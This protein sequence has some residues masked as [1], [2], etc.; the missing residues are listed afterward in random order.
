[1]PQFPYEAG[2]SLRQWLLE[3]PRSGEARAR[4]FAGVATALAYVHATGLVHR[5]LKPDNVL[6][7]ID[8]SAKLADFGISMALEGGG[9]YSTLATSIGGGG[10]GTTAYKSPEQLRGERATPASDAYALGLL[11]HEL[12]YDAPYALSLEARAGGGAEAPPLPASAPPSL[13][14][15]PA[16]VEASAS[17][18]RRLLAPVAAD[19]PLLNAVL[20][21]PVCARAPALLQLRAAPG[22]PLEPGHAAV[23]EARRLMGV[24]LG[25]RPSPRPLA[26]PPGDALVPALAAHIAVS[27]ADAPI[28]T[29]PWRWDLSMGADG[30]VDTERALDAF[31]SASMRPSLQLFVGEEAVLPGAKR[32][33]SEPS[34]LA[35]GAALAQAA[36]QGAVA[37]DALGRLPPFFFDVLQR[38]AEDVLARDLCSLPSALAALA[39]VHPDKA[40]YYRG[41]LQGRAD[42]GALQ[43]PDYLGVPR[44]ITDANKEDVVR[45]DCEDVLV[46]RCGDAWALLRRGFSLG[47]GQL[48]LDAMA[49]AGVPSLRPLVYDPGARE[50]RAA[51][52]GLRG[53]QAA[54]DEAMVARSSKP[55]PSCGVRTYKDGGC[56]HVRCSRCGACVRECG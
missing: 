14:L 17:L 34:L 6:M 29:S 18:L 39:Q 35:F 41:I 37:L 15:P 55:C 7:S 16:F 33:G 51:E 24:A 40:R 27:A 47:G 50:R 22:L 9:L 36:L 31:F 12:V 5:D 30:G 19:R 4:A 48:V 54:A 46:R 20:A 1:M 45:R 11:L 3:E 56:Q 23:A 42:E 53:A 32:A 38:G 28:A 21:D 2:G 8:G 52:A 49:A 13:A 10:A 43:A 26:L 44:D 25:L